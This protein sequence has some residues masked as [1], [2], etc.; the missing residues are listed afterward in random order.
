MTAL[1]YRASFQSGKGI[2]PG[3]NLGQLLAD[4]VEAA[5]KATGHIAEPCL[6]VDVSASCERPSMLHCLGDPPARSG[7]ALAGIPIN[8]CDPGLLIYLT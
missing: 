5:V 8:C 3:N 2:V 1:Y 7:I 6:K 4:V